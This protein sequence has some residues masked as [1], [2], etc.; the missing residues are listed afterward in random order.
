M[1][2]SNWLVRLVGLFLT[3]WAGFVVVHDYSC[4]FPVPCCPSGVPLFI[5]ETTYP[6]SGLDSVSE[7]IIRA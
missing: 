4:H 5:S 3:G 6:A 1:E 2:S 7:F